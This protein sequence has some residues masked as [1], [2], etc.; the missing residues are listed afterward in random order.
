MALTLMCILMGVTSLAAYLLA[1]ESMQ[2][3]ARTFRMAIEKTLES[4]GVS[5]IFVV[6]NLTFAMAAIIAL[7]SLGVFVSMYVT[8]D[9]V[10]VFLSLLQGLAFQWWREL[11]RSGA[12]ADST[13]RTLE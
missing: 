2:L 11:S 1:R 9:F 10:W 5:L 6:G 7:R 8:A 12:A 3:S 13:R 4:I